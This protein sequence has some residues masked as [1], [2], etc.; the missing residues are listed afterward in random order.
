MENL[1]KKQHIDKLTVDLR[2]IA[3][4]FGILLDKKAIITWDS[5]CK[6][7]GFE[8]LGFPSK[9]RTMQAMCEQ[10]H[11][12]KFMIMNTDN[13]I[14]FDIDSYIALE[15]SVDRF[16]KGAFIRLEY[17]IT[18]NYNHKELIL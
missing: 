17:H 14:L 16:N 8:I 5:N 10:K 1:T 3:N 9:N 13:Q 12:P 11:I 4:K 15:C 18:Q 7:V 6:E 2:A